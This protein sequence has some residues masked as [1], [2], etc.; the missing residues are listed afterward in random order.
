MSPHNP[1]AVGSSPT[2]AIKVSQFR[3]TF[4]YFKPTLDSTIIATDG[5]HS[6]SILVKISYLGDISYEITKYSPKLVQ[7]TF[8]VESNGKFDDTNSDTKIITGIAGDP[9]TEIPSVTANPG[10][11]FIWWSQEI[12]TVFPDEDTTYTAYFSEATYT[13]TYHLNGGSDNGN[14]PT[15]FIWGTQSIL[16]TPPTKVGYTFSGWSYSNQGVSSSMTEKV[17]VNN[18]NYIEDGKLNIY[19]LWKPNTYYIIFGNHSSVGGYYAKVS[20][21]SNNL[22]FYKYMYTSTAADATKY[23]NVEY[24]YIPLSDENYDGWKIVCINSEEDIW[25][26]L[27]TNDQVKLLD[28]NAQLLKNIENITDENGN[29]IST[30]NYEVKSISK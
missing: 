22:T 21:N 29:W 3:E 10:Y 17:Y 2:P 13:I 7:V 23:S 11:E 6:A 27:E 18:M 15:E 26:D 25:N 1:E 16:L 30:S 12:P 8:K 4:F 19:A 20:Y 9:L 5:N 24:K 28:N 14:N